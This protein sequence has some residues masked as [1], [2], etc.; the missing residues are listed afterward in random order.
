MRVASVFEE[1]E[2][3][4]DL[5]SESM[6][7][8]YCLLGAL[9][10]DATYP[11]SPSPLRVFT[12]RYD[13]LFPSN[14]ADAVLEC[15]VR[16]GWAKQLDFDGYESP[17]GEIDL[18]GQADA[19]G[20]AIRSPCEVWR[21]RSPAAERWMTLQRA[22]LNRAASLELLHIASATYHFD[23]N[24]AE[25][26]GSYWRWIAPSGGLALAIIRQWESPYSVPARTTDR[27]SLL[28]GA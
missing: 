1:R 25:A 13:L 14:L 2:P 22:T 23:P 15:C 18:L 12:D 5:L 11:L 28:D 9:Q 8:E 10:P 19:A 24:E 21:E 27:R 7:T 3:L 6:V 4:G 17:Q 20:A 16:F 26:L